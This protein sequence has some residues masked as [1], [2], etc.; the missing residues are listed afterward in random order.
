MTPRQRLIHA[1]SD[2]IALSVGMNNPLEAI[3]GVVYGN[4]GALFNEERKAC[5]EYY[6]G[7]SDRSKGRL[8][9]DVKKTRSF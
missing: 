1:A 6:E 7:L 8:V 5:R 4:R 9:K 3:E 2:S